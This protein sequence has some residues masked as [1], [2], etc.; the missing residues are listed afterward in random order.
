MDV[1]Y[2]VFVSFLCPRCPETLIMVV[3]HVHCAP[4]H[5]FRVHHDFLCRRLTVYLGD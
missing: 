2:V 1:G 3:G 5:V 4:A